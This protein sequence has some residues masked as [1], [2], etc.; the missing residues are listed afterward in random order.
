M[1]KNFLYFIWKF[2]RQLLCLI[3]HHHHSRPRMLQRI[4]LNKCAIIQYFISQ[5]VLNRNLLGAK[6]LLEVIHFWLNVSYQEESIFW[7]TF[8]IINFHQNCW[9]V[10]KHTVSSSRDLKKSFD[11]FL[12]LLYLHFLPYFEKKR[13][14]DAT[15][16]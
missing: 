8:Q 13:S 6:H 14:D 1:N 7:E 2:R 10:E 12:H 4:L 9:H 11:I 5:E 15:I 3:Q 16:P